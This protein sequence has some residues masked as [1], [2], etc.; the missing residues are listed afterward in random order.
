MRLVKAL[1]TIEVTINGDTDLEGLETVL[2]TLSGGTTVTGRDVATVT[3][4]DDDILISEVLANI[5][6]ADDETDRE[7][8]ELD[9]HARRKLGRLLLCRIRKRRGRKQWS[10]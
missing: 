1:A 2:V 7:Y 8:I 9:W 10:R 4:A 5:S 6:D 3:I